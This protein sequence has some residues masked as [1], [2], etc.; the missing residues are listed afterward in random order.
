VKI[1]LSLTFVIGGLLLAAGLSRAQAAEIVILDDGRTIQAEKTE[2]I[3]D[4]LR[5]E[6]PAGTIEVPRSAVLSIH[7]A[8]PPGL[9]TAPSAPATVYGD[10]TQQMN[11][12]V[13]QEIQRGQT[14]ARH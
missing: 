14:P 2:I 1:L 5:I 4:R 12:Q 8:A 3:G 7:P 9:S 13:R 6:K 10:M 11:D